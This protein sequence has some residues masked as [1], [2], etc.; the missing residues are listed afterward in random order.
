MFRPSLGVKE[1]GTEGGRY[2]AFRGEGGRPDIE[3]ANRLVP[4]IPGHFSEVAVPLPSSLPFPSPSPQAPS[5]APPSASPNYLT[6]PHPAPSPPTSAPPPF[7]SP[8]SWNL[9]LQLRL[10]SNFLR[11][12]GSPPIDSVVLRAP[13]VAASLPS[14]LNYLSAAPSASASFLSSVPLNAVGRSSVP[15]A[16]VRW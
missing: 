7:A 8:V 9:V 16:P 13:T 14:A 1:G 15:C 10:L 12:P 3:F 4:S 2:G 6:P 5:T 11:Y